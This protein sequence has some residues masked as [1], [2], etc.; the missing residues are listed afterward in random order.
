M[1]DFY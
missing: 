1:H